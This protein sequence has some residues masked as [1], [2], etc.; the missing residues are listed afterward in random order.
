M[1]GD[2][3]LLFPWIHLSAGEDEV[4]L[5]PGYAANVDV[6]VLNPDVEKVGD[7]YF[8]NGERM[9]VEPVVE[10]GNIFKLGTRYS[11]PLGASYVDGGGSVCVDG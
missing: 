1:L 2:E 11:E 7:D 3:S 8:L 6:A 5:A 10:V 9:T 4:V